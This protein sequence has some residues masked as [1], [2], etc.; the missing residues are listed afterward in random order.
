[1]ILALLLAVACPACAAIEAILEEQ[2]QAHVQTDADLLVS[3]VADELLSIDAGRITV[4]SREE[5]RQ[6]F[7]RY[8][9]G[10]RYF[11]WTD[12]E[13]P[14]IR[15]SPDERMALVVR[16]VRVDREEPNGEGGRRRRELVSAFTSTFEK[17]D[18]AWWM[19]TVTST[20]A[21]PDDVR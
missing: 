19:T 2:R 1:M 18:G 7:E 16:R 12:M 6:M 10:A 5:V 13:P 11:A 17:I 14:V 15:V 4:Q 3:H 8:F 21:P 9:D 20:F